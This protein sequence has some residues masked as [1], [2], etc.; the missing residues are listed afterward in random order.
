MLLNTVQGTVV[1]LAVWLEN[2]VWANERLQGSAFENP[3]HTRGQYVC[4]APLALGN[5]FEHN[6]GFMS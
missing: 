3:F 5:K 2:L 6:I 4:T 1:G